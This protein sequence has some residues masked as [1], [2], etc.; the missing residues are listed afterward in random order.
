MLVAQQ[1][2]DGLEAELDRKQAEPDMLDMVC[3]L[4]RKIKQKEALQKGFGSSASSGRHWVWY[5]SGAGRARA[6]PK[7]RKLADSWQ[8]I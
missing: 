7:R 5:R 6:S 1:K 4:K 8:K 3:S 2:F